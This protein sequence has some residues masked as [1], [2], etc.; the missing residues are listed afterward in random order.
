MNIL[1]TGA[2]SFTGYWF[3]K[4]L[5]AAGHDVTATFTRASPTVYADGG[6]REQRIARVQ[7]HCT[8]IWNCSVGDDTFLNA[9]RHGGFDLLCHHAADVTNYKSPDFDAAGAVCNNTKNILPVLT[10]LQA[11]NERAAVLLTQSVFAGGYGAGTLDAAGKLPHFSPY[12]LSKAMTAEMT[13]YYCDQHGI[14][15]GQFV[16]PNPFGPYEEPRFTNYLMKTWFAGNKAG[17]NTPAYVRDNLHVELMAR[18]YVQCAEQLQSH[19][20]SACVVG[21]H[22]YI[23]TQGAFAERFAAEMRT[24]LDLPCELEL[25]HQTEFTE[26]RIRINTDTPDADALGFDESKAW[27]DVAAFYK[28]LYG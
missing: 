24:R 4:Q 26:P 25:A 28:S 3:V 27:D 23:E 10:E 11:N 15:F 7:E 9:I 2:S 21:P 18:V 6:V 20:E 19:P 17:C 14:P 1:F 8:P 5:A 16:I 12:G 13:G 22:G